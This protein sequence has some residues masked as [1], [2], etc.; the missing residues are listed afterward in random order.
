MELQYRGKHILA[1]M[2]YGGT[3]PFRMLAAKYGADI[4]YGER[5]VDHLFSWRN[6]SYCGLGGE[7]H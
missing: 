5:I 3:L 4:T 7:G 2:V 6:V 1:P